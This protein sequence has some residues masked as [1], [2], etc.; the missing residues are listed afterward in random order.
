MRKR[1]T[2]PSTDGKPPQS[3]VGPFSCGREKERSDRT[4]PIAAMPG[5]AASRHDRAAQ[6]RSLTE[7]QM[8]QRRSW[9]VTASACDRGLDFLFSFFVEPLCT[10][11]APNLH[12]V[13]PMTKAGSGVSDGQGWRLRMHPFVRLV[14]IMAV[15]VLA[16]LG[17]VVL[18]GVMSSR[19]TD[20]RA[21]LDGRVADLWGSPQT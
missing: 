19:T 18:G 21:T 2:G 4:R 6:T 11:P 9:S 14:G 17:W 3:L 1:R 8:S 12:G 7:S 16:A 13:S 20:Q 15:F 5:W 10:E